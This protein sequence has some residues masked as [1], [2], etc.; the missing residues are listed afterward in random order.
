MDHFFQ[1]MSSQAEAL[2]TFQLCFA[3]NVQKFWHI[4]ES[5]YDVTIQLKPL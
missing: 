1:K 2:K 5:T 3:Q 4:L